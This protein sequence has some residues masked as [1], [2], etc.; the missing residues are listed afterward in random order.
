MYEAQVIKQ[1]HKPTFNNNTNNHH[2]AQVTASVGR[3]YV[4]TDGVPQPHQGIPIS[5]GMVLPSHQR[6]PSNNSMSGPKSPPP[7]APKP[8]NS[9]SLSANLSELDILLQDLSSAQFMEEVDRKNAGKHI[10][11]YYN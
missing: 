11:L 6:S 2:I 1:Q 9:S 4:S 5:P 3:Q 7:V 8:T 10:T